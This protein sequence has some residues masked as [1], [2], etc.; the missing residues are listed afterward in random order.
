ML[1]RPMLQ[2]PMLRRPMLWRWVIDATALAREHGRIADSRCWSAE[3]DR[4]RK[5]PRSPAR[6]RVSR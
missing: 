2:R 5:G 3:R 6:K 4:E 1:R